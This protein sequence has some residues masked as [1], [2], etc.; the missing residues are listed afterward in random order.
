M[1]LSRP[2]RSRLTLADDPAGAVPL[3]LPRR[4]LWPVALAFLV[5]FAI[6]AGV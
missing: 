4:R 5:M 2:E 6:F 3:E 1:T